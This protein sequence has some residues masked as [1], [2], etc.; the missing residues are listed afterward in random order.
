MPLVSIKTKTNCDRGVDKFCF[1]L[2]E[3]TEYIYARG[4]WG[5]A[6]LSLPLKT[7]TLENGN[8]VELM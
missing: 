1:L 6:S 8:M 7:V 5:E 2:A 4:E 3:G